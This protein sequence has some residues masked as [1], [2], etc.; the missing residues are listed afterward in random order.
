MPCFHLLCQGNGN[1]FILAK[2]GAW[3]VT[4]CLTL[5]GQPLAIKTTVLLVKNKE[6]MNM[7]KILAKLVLNIHIIIIIL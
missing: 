1:E 2:L 3:L 6:M 5:C 7:L 4:S